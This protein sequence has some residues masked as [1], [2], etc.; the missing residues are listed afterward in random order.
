MLKSIKEAEEGWKADLL[1]VFSI[2]CAPFM[3]YFCYLDMQYT[4]Q[5]PALIQPLSYVDY[6][7][8]HTHNFKI[9]AFTV[10]IG[11]AG[12]LFGPI[13]A[14]MRLKFR[15]GQQISTLTGKLSRTEEDSSLYLSF[16][17]RYKQMSKI[18]V[19]TME[20]VDQSADSL[21]PEVQQDLM[22]AIKEIAKELSK[23]LCSNSQ[24]EALNVRKMLDK[25]QNHFTDYIQNHN[26]QL[27]ISCPENLTVVADPLFT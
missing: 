21:S 19:K 8:S 18:I 17:Q 13:F 1:R 10:L 14:R 4:S 22:T 15:F 12:V 6:L 7:L 2:A 20:Y 25:T 5:D 3:V 27:N 23:G 9:I 11:S 26:I 16:I 24:K